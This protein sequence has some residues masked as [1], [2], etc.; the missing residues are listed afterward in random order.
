MLLD[1]IGEH[2]LKILKTV[3]PDKWK[4]ITKKLAY[5]YE[6]FNSIEDYNKPVNNL[7]NKEF[8]SKLKNKCPDDKEIDR[9]REII[10]KFNIKDGK[11][12]TELCCKSDVLLLTCVF[13]KFIKVSQ[14]KF[15]ISPLY[16]V[17]LAGYTWSCGLKYTNIKLQ[18]L[19]DKE[20]I[21]LLENRIRGGISGVM[22]DRYIKSDENT[23]VIYFDATNLYGF[24]MS[25]SLPYNEINFETE[26][27]CLEE[28]LNTPDDNDKGYFLEVDLEYP[29]NIRQKTKHFPFCPENETVSK[30]DF[31]PYMKSIMPKNYVSHKKLIF[32]WT[33][34]KNNLIHYRML[35]FYVRHGMKIKEVHR[36]ISF[37]QSKWLE[38]HI[39]FNTQKRNQ[40]VND[41]EK[42]FYK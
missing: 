20:L 30:N 17:S 16:F 21:L 37:K 2:D 35:K 41:F 25:Q 34:K 11:E 29:H 42:D 36:V 15:G 22:G 5:P 14:N 24:G 19:Q 8:F 7:E 26:N 28:I 9:T 38:K 1:Y 40:A 4:Y 18:T 13:E 39:D 31:G 33:D 3:C 32:D 12:L 10:K 6:Y 23:N 27:I